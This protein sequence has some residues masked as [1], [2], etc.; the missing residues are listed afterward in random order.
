MWASCLSC[1]TWSG[2]PACRWNWQNNFAY[3]YTASTMFTD[4]GW[5]AG[6]VNFRTRNLLF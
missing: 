6:W 3:M 5:H 2:T 4:G 1:S